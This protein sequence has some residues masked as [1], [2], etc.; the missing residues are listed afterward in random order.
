M[1]HNRDP[2]AWVRS[3]Y[4]QPVRIVNYDRVETIPG[5]SGFHRVAGNAQYDVRW[6][7]VADGGLL[8]AVRE[9][10]DS[11]NT[12]AFSPDGEILALESLDGTARLWAVP[13]DEG[14]R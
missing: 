12:V 13:E 5:G 10:A 7:R 11:V 8:R 3:A 14:A 4:H 1:S 9:R 6:W 2:K